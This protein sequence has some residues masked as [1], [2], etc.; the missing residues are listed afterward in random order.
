MPWLGCAPPVK[1]VVCPSSD[2]KRG[3]WPAVVQRRLNCGRVNGRLAPPAPRRGRPARSVEAALHAVSRSPRRRRDQRRDGR[4]F[5]RPGV[6]ELDQLV[7]AVDGEG[8][9]RAEQRGAAGERERGEEEEIASS[10]DN[11]RA[12]RDVPLA[13]DYPRPA[14]IKGRRLGGLVR[15]HV[16]MPFAP[17]LSNGLAHN[18]GRREYGGERARAGPEASGGCAARF[19]GTA[20]GARQATEA[21]RT[22][23]APAADANE[24][25]GNRVLSTPHRRTCRRYVD[26]LAARSLA[27]TPG[28]CS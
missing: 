12:P 3:D 10:R 13:V 18:C 16:P 9:G 17:S 15:R 11:Q 7:L 8:R 2:S 24:Q 28:T 25:L 19:A 6:I 1:I 5:G 23:R 20:I 14:F 21:K 22:G 27:G 4:R 26:R